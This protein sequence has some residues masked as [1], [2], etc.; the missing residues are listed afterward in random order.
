MIP[1]AARTRKSN[2]TVRIQHARKNRARCRSRWKRRAITIRA[3]S[4]GNA[5][6]AAGSPPSGRVQEVEASI[7]TSA[8]LHRLTPFL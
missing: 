4:I 7:E 6:P 2:E 8:Q 1:F 3:G 5:T